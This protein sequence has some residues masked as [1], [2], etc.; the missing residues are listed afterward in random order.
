[1][2]GGPSYKHG[3]IGENHFNYSKEDKGMKDILFSSLDV[4][5]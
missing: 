5:P 2:F 4:D 1:M 3:N